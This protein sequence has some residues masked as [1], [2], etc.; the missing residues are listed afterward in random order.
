VKREGW[1]LAA[2][3]AVVGT[4][5]WSDTVALGLEERIVDDQG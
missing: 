1:D 2:P 5:L 4:G 3:A